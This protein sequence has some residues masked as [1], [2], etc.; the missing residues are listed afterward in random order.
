MS[1]GAVGEHTP[2]RDHAEALARAAHQVDGPRGKTHVHDGPMKIEGPQS[3]EPVDRDG[4][5]RT[6]IPRVCRIG[7]VHD[8]LDAGALQ[9]HGGDGASNAAADD[10]CLRHG[11]LPPSSW[12]ASPVDRSFLSAGANGTL[13]AVALRT[14][15]LPRQRVLGATGGV[16][17]RL[18]TDPAGSVESPPCDGVRVCIHAGPPI[19]ALSRYGSAQHRGTVIFGDI[20]IIPARLP[21]AWELRGTDVNLVITIEEELLR[22]VVQ[23]SHADPRHLEI[24]SRFQARDPR[25]EHIGWALKAEMESGYPS[26]A[27]Y[28]DSLAQGLAACIVRNHSSIARE[29]ATERSAMSARRL[30]DAT[31]FIEDNLGRHLSLGDIAMVTGLSVSQFTVQFRRSTGVSVHQYVIRRRVDRAAALLRA[32]RLSINQ[33]AVEVGS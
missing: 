29:P 27:L 21:A 32:G 20:D 4:E 25:I 18:M 19:Y 33:V 8:R 17:L 3:V 7:F 6:R 14:L 9:R 10:E 22:R 5:E 1:R 2:D 28:L 15:D 30:R 16:R 12:C 13:M 24:R 23:G 26:G 31:S 11:A